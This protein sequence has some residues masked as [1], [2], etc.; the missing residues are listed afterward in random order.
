MSETQ[1]DLRVRELEEKLKEVT[2]IANNANEAVKSVLASNAE[3]KTIVEA[4]IE[5][6]KQNAE[7]I[8]EH[9]A[10]LDNDKDAIVAEYEQALEQVKT[11]IIDSIKMRVDGHLNRVAPVEA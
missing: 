7:V 2:T 5:H 10:Q 4:T 6:A 11:S 1:L 3:L 9:I 8:V